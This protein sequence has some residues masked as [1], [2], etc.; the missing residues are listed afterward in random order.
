MKFA[1][2]MPALIL[3]PP[4]NHT[5]LFDLAADPNEMNNLAGDRAQAQRIEQMMGWLAE[6]QKAAGDN[7]PLSVDDPKPMEID[8]SGFQR[9]PDRWQPQWIIDKYFPAK[10]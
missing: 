1:L 8:L 10:E 3:Y 2:G 7:L 4:I 9:T 5:Q 6:G